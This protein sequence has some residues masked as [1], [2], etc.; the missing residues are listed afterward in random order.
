MAIAQMAHQYNTRYILD[1]LLTPE[2]NEV[3]MNDIRYYC[4]AGES[5]SFFDLWLRARKRPTGKE[6]AIGYQRKGCRP[7]INPPTKLQKMTFGI[8]DFLIV[9]S[10]GNLEY[11]DA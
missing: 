9:M 10:T 1:E 4:D 8:G 5:V 6:I 3:Y 2:G 11:T 7:I